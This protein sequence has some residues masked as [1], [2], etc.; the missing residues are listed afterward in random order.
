[1]RSVCPAPA[2]WGGQRPT[3]R[4]VGY[5]SLDD[6]LLVHPLLSLLGSVL[7]LVGCNDYGIVKQPMRE[8]FFQ[9][10]RDTVD[11]LLVIDDSPSM[12]EETASI[13]VAS[14]TLIASLLLLEVDLR[15]RVVTTSRVELLPWTPA[16]SI[17][18]LDELLTP[19]VVSLEGDRF[20]AGLDVA[21]EAATAV[22]DT[23]VLHIVFISDEDDASERS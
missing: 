21:V 11:L 2:L 15:V 16:D 4:K 10:A 12:L 17:T 6:L 14:E 1:M 19:L 8:S 13:D 7:G 3:G 23:A 22:R 20:E 9:D 18:Q 5:A